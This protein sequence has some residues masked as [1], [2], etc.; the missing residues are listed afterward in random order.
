MDT[1]T[2]AAPV[3]NRPSLQ[4]TFGLLAVVALLVV[5]FATSS[6]YDSWYALFKTVH[7]TFA[8]IWIGG[9]FL[10]MLLGIIAEQKNDPAE[11]AIVARQAAMVS[12]K[13][14]APAGLIVFLMGI[15]MMLN[16]DWGWG[17][18]WIVAGLVGYAATFLTGLLVLSP[19]A[20][21]IHA[22]VEANGPTH[23]ETIALI[24]RIMF[25]IRFDMAVL[26]LVIADM[27]TKPFS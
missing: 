19:L 8:V 2:S 9:G 21:K 3:S 13:L 17:S 7:V 1:P 25:I 16:I 11:I 5:V 20:K 18:F 22:S 6:I 15:A 10:L 27:V 14:F 24:K 23:P 12:E 4:L 26:L